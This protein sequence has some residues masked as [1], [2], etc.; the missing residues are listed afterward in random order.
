MS[1][2]EKVL[3]K[4]QKLLA[5][6]ESDNPHEAANALAKAQLLM[7]KH[8]LG[9]KELEL[10]KMTRSDV[11]LPL[12]AARDMWGQQLAG[13]ITVAFGVRCILSTSYV[14]FV[15]PTDRVEIAKYTYEVLGRQLVEARRKFRANAKISHPNNYR[16]MTKLFC[17]GWVSSV[18]QKVKEFAV[19]VEEKEVVEMFIKGEFGEVGSSK[20][21][22]SKVESH[23]E[24][25]ALREGFIAG[26][27]VSLHVPMNG[28]ETVKIG[29]K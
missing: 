26:E 10:S 25:N 15:G 12:K 4:I 27:D 29:V 3:S 14:S 16:K 9:V 5:L 6:S 19:D 28:R 11:D 8:G 23:E 13:L 20:A 24:R 22:G 1:N 17:S 21:R 7:E 2:N 18:Y